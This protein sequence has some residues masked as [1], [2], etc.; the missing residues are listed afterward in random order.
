MTKHSTLELWNYLLNEQ[1]SLSDS[2]QCNN[3]TKKIEPRREIIDT[4]LAYANSVKV[5]KTKKDKKFLIS[6]N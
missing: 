4:I 6:L 3:S 1:N 2:F 5:I